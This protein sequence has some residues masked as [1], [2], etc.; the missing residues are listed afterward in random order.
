MPLIPLLPVLL[1]LFAGEC[2]Q[3]EDSCTHLGSRI[4]CAAWLGDK[5]PRAAELLYL[6][7]LE[8]AP[9]KDCPLPEARALNG[10]G[11]LEIRDSRLL[12]AV[13]HLRKAEEI[14]STVE[15]AGTVKVKVVRNLG[16]AYLRLNWLDEALDAIR[17]TED[18][19]HIYEPEQKDWAKLRLQLSR[20]LRAKGRLQDARERIEALALDLDAELVAAI[21]QELGWIELEKGDLEA[22][23]QS[24][25]KSVQAVDEASANS[26]AD[27]YPDMAELRL[28][29]RRWD[30]ALVWIDKTNELIDASRNSDFNL[31]GL[32]F[33]L[34]ARAYGGLGELERSK[35]AADRGLA[36]VDEMRA[37]WNVQGREYFA[38]RQK[39]YRYRLDLGVAGDD[40]EDIWAVFEGYRARSLL[41]VLGR[42][43]AGEV[44]PEVEYK[45]SGRRRSLLAAIRLLD[46]SEGGDERE[47]NEG[48]FRSRLRELREA[49]AEMEGSEGLPAAI[50]PEEAGGHLDGETLG[51]AYTQGADR[52]HLL[53]LDPRRKLATFTIDADLPELEESVT[54][55][56]AA[57]GLV[58]GP[59]SAN[60]LLGRELGRVLLGP[61]GD[62][63]D[64]Y[65]RLA[66]VT[67][68]SL[69]KLPFEVLRDP[70]TGQALIERHEVAYLPSFSVLRASRRRIGGHCSPPS[71][72]L[73]AMGDP[74]FG[75]EDDRWPADIEDPRSEDESLI[76]DRLPSTAAEVR[77][78][79]ELYPDG[80]TL[81]EGPE[82]TRERFLEEA[83]KHRTIHIASHAW[84]DPK[85]PELSKI[86]L[87]CFDSEGRV[88]ET[89]DVYFEDAVSLPLCGQIVVLSACDTA[90]GPTVD[91]EGTFG[92]PRAF[93]HAGAAS[94]V[95]S[96][97]PVAD[98]PTAKLM[99]TFHERLSKG[100]EPAAALREAKL[101]V[102]HAGGPPSVWAAFVLVGDWRLS[103]SASTFPAL[104]GPIDR[105]N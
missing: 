3:S 51:L 73:L 97:W 89:C 65:R 43:T 29:Q 90:D 10:L 66:I 68:G 70:R 91:G 62:R 19:Y 32:V 42:Q 50:G 79:S 67:E 1:L 37:T 87:S 35:R 6:K 40:P 25:E 61:L 103:K 105:I 20:I 78:I 7:V 96:L 72:P 4:D 49:L 59:G 44:E 14:L 102:L 38:R 58:K 22:A 54:N 69:E 92:L 17:D 36:L 77:N 85:V 30:E 48:K 75:S 71:T 5:E 86:A 28:R 82:A 21:W 34:R 8:S 24:F 41:A 15:G 26:R 46:Q 2:G 76:L 16:E 39:F 64:S 57:I 53:V 81:A 47:S 63:L 56:L 101:E 23:E 94:V 13:D 11:V 9:S 18:L 93:L 83:P 33:H 60:D 99:L 88:P 12:E 95:A 74:V 98:E 27:V 104:S 55:L 31:E 80:V 45:V 100:H 52:V 84:S